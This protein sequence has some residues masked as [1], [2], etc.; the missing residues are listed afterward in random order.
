MAALELALFV[1]IVAG[2][3]V[4]ILPISST[5]LLVVLVWWSLHRRHMTWASIG[6]LWPNKVVVWV[7]TGVVAAVVLQLWGTWVQEPFFDRLTGQTQDLSQFSQ[8]K[9]NLGFLVVMLILNWLL[10]AFGEE[11][12]YR[13]YLLNRLADLF[14]RTKLGWTAAVVF[15]SAA[16]GVAHLWQGTSGVLDASVMGVWYALLYLGANRNLLVPAVA[17]G[18]NNTNGLCLIY[19]GYGL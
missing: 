7:L 10:A 12:A 16:F 5:P 17:H 4:G 15:G 2:H 6:L 18:V 19:L 11:T 8:M 3:T 13:G 1:G 14:G 9:D